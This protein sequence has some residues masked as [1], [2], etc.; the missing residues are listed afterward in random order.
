M[1]E[2]KNM[3]EENRANMLKKSVPQTVPQTNIRSIAISKLL[4]YQNQ[5]LDTN[6]NEMADKWKN[7]SS[8]VKIVKDIQIYS[9]K[10]NKNR[11]RIQS[12]V[13]PS[14]LRYIAAYEFS[15]VKMYCEEV[16]I[17][18]SVE[19]VGAYSFENDGTINR[20]SLSSNTLFSYT[21]FN[22]TQV[23]EV[24]FRTV[25]NQEQNLQVF[26]ANELLLIH[27]PN[28]QFIL[29]MQLKKHIAKNRY[30]NIAFY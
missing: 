22:H 2:D 4:P 24:L 25:S 23:K 27:N 19:E 30:Q 15:N 12:I 29:P 26:W 11:K 6:P 21:A 1:K 16:F 5:I 28:V 18:D 9:H 10:N 17:P 13:F 14:T 8:A 20:F 7:I 3:I